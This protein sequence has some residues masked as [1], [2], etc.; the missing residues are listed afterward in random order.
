MDT[1]ETQNSKVATSIRIDA[2]VY[3]AIAKL[4]EA[5]DRPSQANM[6]ERLLKTHPRVREILGVPQEISAN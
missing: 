3:A 5:E 2:E 6:V 1:T 4:A